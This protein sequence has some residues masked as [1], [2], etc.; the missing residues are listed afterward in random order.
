MT[1]SIYVSSLAFLGMNEE[2]I[3]S[4]AI[5]NNLAIEF[6]SGLKY[7][8]D[9]EEMY[10]N[11]A[12]KRMPHNY[13]PAPEVPFVLNLASENK[14]IRELSIRHCINGLKL[15][16]YARSPFFAAHAGFC[17]DPSA[18]E[19]GKKIT[20][21]KDYNKIK[22]REIFLESISKILSVANDLNIDF[23]I[24]NNVLA[25]FNFENGSNPLLCCES[26]EIAW[27]FD[28]IKDHRLG[29]LLDT[30]HLKVSCKTLNLDLK[31]ELMSI[32]PYIKGLHHSDNDGEKDDNNPI[33]EEYWFLDYMKLFLNLPHVLEVKSIAINDI[34]AQLKI[35]QSLWN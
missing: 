8:P 26:S 7:R 6:S 16:K 29:L 17:V 31:E 23:L 11:A 35:L 22:N 21:R 3:I 18:V 19:L 25:A 10:L 30:A 24:E 13:F 33:S 4:I 9:M 32:I 14:G 5:E 12:I 28:S 34:K 1:K 15:A 20:I 27:L 2:E